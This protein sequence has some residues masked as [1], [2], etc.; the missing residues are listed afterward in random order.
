[1]KLYRFPDC[2]YGP[3]QTELKATESEWNHSASFG[4]SLWDL[5]H[6]CKVRGLLVQKLGRGVSDNRGIS[7]VRC[8]FPDGRTLLVNEGNIHVKKIHHI[9]RVIVNVNS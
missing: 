7:Y 3:P 6:E 5:T 8:I 4:P 2:V 9:Q 1:M